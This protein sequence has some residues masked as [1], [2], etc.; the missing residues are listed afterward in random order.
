MVS[1]HVKAVSG[2]RRLLGGSG[3]LNQI[4]KEG[5]DLEKTK[6][7]LPACQC[8]L[9]PNTFL[10]LFTESK[11]AGSLL[12][13]WVLC[14]PVEEQAAGF[15]SPQKASAEMEKPLHH[16]SCLALCRGWHQ[17]SGSTSCPSR[18]KPPTFLGNP[19]K[20]HRASRHLPFLGPQFHHW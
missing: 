16:S 19:R 3:E 5:Q 13:H 17:H 9:E 1:G 7:G 8:M 11:R 12:M 2:H 15:S 10:P 18:Q 20:L 4:L 14:A 6:V